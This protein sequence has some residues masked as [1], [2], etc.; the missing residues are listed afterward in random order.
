MARISA[1]EFSMAEVQWYY[2]RNN[3]QFGPVSAGE[4]KQLADSG[5][6]APDDLLWREGMDAWATAINLRGLF[7]EGPAAGSSKVAGAGGSMTMGRSIDP[8]GAEPYVAAPPGLR[9]LLRTTQTVL[10]A[11]CV[12]V[13]LV[14]IVLF[15]RDF[16][17]ATDPREEAAAAAVFSTFFIGAYV[18][19]RCGE[20]LSRLL[21]RSVRR[22][23]R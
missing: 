10:W 20:K 5:R 8:I 13:V 1:R 11:T 9:S 12:L 22:R 15:T 7:P 18:L 6:L 3:Q 14:G 17:K 21:L 2:A 16:L 23:S 4:L 19:A